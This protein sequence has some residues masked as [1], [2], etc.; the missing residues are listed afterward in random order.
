MHGKSIPQT[1]R[2]PGAI[3]QLDMYLSA[4]ENLTIE[5]LLTDAAHIII[6][7]MR[8]EAQHTRMV[9]KGVKLSSNVKKLFANLNRHIQLNKNEL[10]SV[11]LAG[12]DKG[13]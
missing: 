4:T 6:K 7:K 5:R 1:P 10:N 2:P 12:S 9:R 11:N 8:Y 13:E 3:Q